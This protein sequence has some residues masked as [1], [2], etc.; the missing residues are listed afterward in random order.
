MRDLRTRTRPVA[1]R[2]G[3]PQHGQLRPPSGRRLGGLQ[4]ALADWRG[5]PHELGALG[6][7][8]GAGP[9]RQLARCA[10]CPTEW[11]AVGANVSTMVGAWPRRASERRRVLS[12]EPEFTSA[13]WP[14]MAQGRGIAGSLR[15]PGPAGRG[16]RRG[17]RRRELQ[18]RSVVDRRGGG[19]RRDSGG[20]RPST[21]LSPW[22]MPLR[23][24]AGSRS[25][26]SRFD[27]LVVRR[28]QVALLA[29]W[30]GVHERPARDGR[31]AHAARRPAGTPAPTRT[32]PTTGRPCGWPATPAAST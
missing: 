9:R 28:L 21:A 10:R 31:A 26:A 32:R 8:H 13:L 22:W 1:P 24:A 4:E 7:R 23:P 3:L 2:G 5:G 11:M 16:D 30:S 18:R 15:T 17:H 27:V 29:A 14:F 25:D 20:G 12:T 19:S 6:R